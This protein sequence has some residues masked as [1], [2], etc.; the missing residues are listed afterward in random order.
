MATT[1]AQ[2]LKRHLDEDVAGNEP[3]AKR[4]KG[5]DAP[6]AVNHSKQQS[7]GLVV[8]SVDDY[9]ESGTLLPALKQLLSVYKV[10]SSFANWN[11]REST[12]HLLHQGCG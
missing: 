10:G 7:D 2:P 5:G 6:Q 9:I 3:S 11:S 1:G 4:T 8:P 12:C